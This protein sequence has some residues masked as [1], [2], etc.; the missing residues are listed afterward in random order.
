MKLLFVA[1]FDMEFT[2]ILG[3]LQTVET[4]HAGIRWARTGTLGTHSVLLAANGAGWKRAEAATDAGWSYLRPDVV[5][6]T[7]FCGALAG[8]LR[9][10]DI[11]SATN[12]NGHPARA[13][14]GATPAM[15][16][17]VRSIDHIART[18]VE[19]ARLAE[20]GECAVEMEAAAVAE[21]SEFHGT[22]FYCVRSVTDLADEDL[23]ND[24]N[25]ALRPDGHF[26]TIQVLTGAL[27]QPAVRLPELL[28]L[29]SR[30]AQAAHSLGDF[31]ADC[32]F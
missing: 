18:A 3:R 27:R 6:S 5:I 19:K 21:R 20:T 16:G 25:S 14:A 28:R 9:I 24:F 10:A 4:V 8:N 12:V 22:P 2:G 17:G 1:A 32:R 7:G 26:A 23:A 13:I 29:R 11:V 30:C 31:F 15:Q